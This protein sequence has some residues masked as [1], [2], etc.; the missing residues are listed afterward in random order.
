MIGE[1]YGQLKIIDHAESRVSSGQTKRYVV[2]ECSC[3]EIKQ[4]RYSHL[5]QGRITSC[6][7]VRVGRRTHGQSG[8]RLYVIWSSMKQRCYYVKSKAYPHYGG[9][10]VVICNKWLH[11]FENFHKWSVEN[12]YT[13]DL[14]IDRKNN[15]KIYSPE[16]CEWI[17]LQ[18]NIR[19]RDVCKAGGSV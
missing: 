5:T 15:A 3:G 6:G 12:G 11:D 18:E 16:T 19:R 2:A 1:V 7:C 4:V 9:K 13:D 10:G 17:T 8:T 14:T